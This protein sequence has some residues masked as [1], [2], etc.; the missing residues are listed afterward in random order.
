MK[1]IFALALAALST[2]SIFAAI[3]SQLTIYLDSESKEVEARIAAGDT[4]SPFNASSSASFVPMY[5]N[6]S[7]IGMYVVYQGSNYMEL[8]A[9]ELQNI[10]LVIVTSREAAA[11]QTYTFAVELG[12]NNSE[13]VYVTDFRP[14]GGGDPV[15]FQLTN[16]T[17]YHFTLNNEAAYVEGQNCVIADRFVI[18]YARTLDADLEI[19]HKDNQ[20][21]LIQNPY[22]ENIVIKDSEGTEVK[23]VPSTNTPQYIDLSDLAAGQYTVE[24]NNGNRSFIIK[25]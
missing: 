15:K 10:P 25:K 20:L 6:A 23:N 7:N 3:N 19:C 21:Q 22:A 1:K 9:P 18:N 4:Y 13:A 2:A 14:D 24:L 17:E 11:K 12:A 5:P 16:T 8:N